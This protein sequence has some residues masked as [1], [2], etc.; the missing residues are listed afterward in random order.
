M[1]KKFT[2][3]CILLFLLVDSYAI[4]RI[5]PFNQGLHNTPV[6]LPWVTSPFK[7]SQCSLKPPCT[8]QD[9]WESL[10]NRLGPETVEQKVTNFIEKHVPCLFELLKKQEEGSLWEEII[11]FSQSEPLVKVIVENDFEELEHLLAMVNYGSITT[12]DL[13]KK[14]EIASL[15]LSIDYLSIA[16]MGAFINTSSENRYR[17]FRRLL[18]AG[19]NPHSTLILGQNSLPLIF[20]AL[21][22]NSSEA[23][24][25]LLQHKASWP[26]DHRLSDILHAY[27]EE[28]ECRSPGDLVQ[29][30]DQYQAI[31]IE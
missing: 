11:K 26:E 28:F 31:C 13:N 14:C 6:C 23:L 24:A 7:R 17:I 27:E 16:F 22:L 5:E 2:S 3:F 9:Y 1:N 25:E 15:N 4:A 19:C 8:S 20:L 18:T 29:F 30:G 10:I 12:I 21:L